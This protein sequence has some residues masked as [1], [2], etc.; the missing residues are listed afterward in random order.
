MKNTK[1]TNQT[2]E[3]KQEDKVMKNAIEKKVR[4]KKEVKEVKKEAALKTEAKVEKAKVEKVKKAKVEKKPTV[5]QMTNSELA[6]LFRD[7]GCLTKTKASDESK[8]V[9][10]TFGTH[11]R[12]LQQNRAYQLLLT[13]GH[14]MKKGILVDAENDDTA[15][16]V[17]WYNTLTDEQ[18]GYVNGFDT[19]T[20][21]KLATTEMPRERTVKIVNY[22]LLVEYIKYMATFTENQVA[23]K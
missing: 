5:P 8:V 12:I 6:K 16:F 17:E 21:T 13:N 4:A 14:E 22:E 7:N 9:Y 11:S 20:A 15:R 1:T 19:I 2:K 23:E 3:T 10:N 18:K